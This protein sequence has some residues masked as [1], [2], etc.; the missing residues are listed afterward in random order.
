M[1]RV[2]AIGDVHGCDAA[3][4]ALL[5]RVRPATA[6][7]VV[8]LGDLV[9]RGPNTKAVLDAVLALEEC[10]RVVL[11]RGNHEETML[12]ALDGT[13]WEQWLAMGGD[14]TLASYGGDLRAVPEAHV[15]L[16]KKSRDYWETAS[17]IFVHA[18]LLHEAPLA[19][20]HPLILRWT[21]L[22]RGQSWYEPGRRVVCGHTPQPS[23]FPLVL[24][25]WV[26]IDTDCQ[27]GG[28]LTCLDVGSDQVFQANE[29]GQQRAFPL[30][31]RG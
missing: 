24:P 1:S 12:R 25:G 17:T 20:Q 23:G 19:E 18:N 31:R 21:H 5:E 28:W 9:N 7:V 15:R 22:D 2:L 13:A 6:D 8:F 11:V 14:A 26:C 10:C 16:L 3:L 27:R 30:G 4:G 29:Q